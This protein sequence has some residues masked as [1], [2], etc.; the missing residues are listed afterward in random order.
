MSSASGHRPVH[1]STNGETDHTNRMTGIGPLRSSR[2]KV[3]QD[4]DKV[5]KVSGSRELA[6]P[7]VQVGFAVRDLATVQGSSVSA[8]L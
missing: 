8:V 2:Q 7:R 5:A 4:N 6:S 3:I 1:Q